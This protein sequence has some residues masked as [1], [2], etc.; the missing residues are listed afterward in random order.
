MWRLP[1]ASPLAGR[2][3]PEG[4]GDAA[5]AW[6]AIWAADKEAARAGIDAVPD[7][8]ILD[9][10]QHLPDTSLRAAALVC[11][12]WHALLDDGNFWKVWPGWPGR[13][14]RDA[15]P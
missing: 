9:V 15:A 6:D 1:F 5:P 7:E 8:L 2:A 4:A 11:R 10:L 12:R 14:R 13:D 3:H